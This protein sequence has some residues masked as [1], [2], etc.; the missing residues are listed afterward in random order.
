M[1]TYISILTLSQEGENIFYLAVEDIETDTELLIGY[2]D[3]DLESDEEDGHM[4]TVINEGQMQNLDSQLTAS[5]KGMYYSLFWMA[6]ST[7][8]EKRNTWQWGWKIVSLIVRRY[9]L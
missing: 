1:V 4:A 6:C 8:S 2:L 3:S 5:R 7:D 9:D